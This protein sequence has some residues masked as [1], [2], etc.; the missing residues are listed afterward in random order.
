MKMFDEIGSVQN[1]PA[2]L[3]KV[4]SDKNTPLWGFGHRVFKAYDPR[5]R[6]M[7]EMLLKFRKDIAAP[8]DSR[9]E[10][11][12]ALEEMAL[13]DDYFIK[14]SLFPNLDF[15]SG[16]LMKQ[17][18]IPDNMFNVIFALSRSMGWIAHWREMMSD[19]VIKIYRPR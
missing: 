8:A 11:A 6:M 10:V 7:K 2:F 14:R 17:L 5:A 3:E 18:M 16:L 19:N 9:L 13:K 1:I 4:K 12:M 15:Y